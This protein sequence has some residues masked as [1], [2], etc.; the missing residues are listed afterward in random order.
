MRGS[1]ASVVVFTVRSL[2]LRLFVN[3]SNIA[4]VCFV[5]RYSPLA[6]PD[7][8]AILLFNLIG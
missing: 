4:Y 6:T 2:T 8:A 7:S 1:N 5:G 3:E